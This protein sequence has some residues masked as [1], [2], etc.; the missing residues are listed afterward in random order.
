MPTVYIWYPDKDHPYGHAALQTDKYHIS[1][2]PDGDVK[3]DLGVARAVAGNGVPGCL[4]FHPE[5]DRFYEGIRLPTGI[6]ELDQEKVT[7]EAI[8]R[9]HE[10]FLHYNGIDTADVTLEAGEK[11][12]DQSTPPEVSVSKTKY[13]IVLYNIIYPS[14]FYYEYVNN[15]VSFCSQVILQAGKR[16]FMNELVDIITDNVT[17]PILDLFT[18]P[19]F[20]S[21][22]KKNWVKG[23]GWNMLNVLDNA[24]TRSARY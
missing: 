8:N 11:L 20:E 24:I 16:S 6:Y 18:V 15:C 17:F 14:D 1:F 21:H 5:L 4:I 2:W 13:A 9:I 10:K 19:W 22:I 23:S 7:D 3:N 12:V